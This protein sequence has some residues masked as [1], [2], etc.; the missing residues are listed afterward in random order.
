M[1]RGHDQL[2]RVRGVM[3]SRLMHPDYREA[4]STL[5]ILVMLLALSTAPTGGI[6]FKRHSDTAFKKIVRTLL[7]RGLNGEAIA[8]QT[9]GY[10]EGLLAQ[11]AIVTDEVG[12][13]SWLDWRFWYSFGRSCC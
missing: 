11:G 10:Y 8:K 2:A 12:D 9:A 3:L 13:H 4:R 6:G 7:K 1:E 5:T